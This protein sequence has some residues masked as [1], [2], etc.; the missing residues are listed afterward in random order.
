MWTQSLQLTLLAPWFNMLLL[1]LVVLLLFKTQKLQKHLLV[2]NGASN[3]KQNLLQQTIVQ[4]GESLY[5]G[6][7]VWLDVSNQLQQLNYDYLN[8]R[9]MPEDYAF[10][11]DHLLDEP[12]YDIAQIEMLIQVYFPALLPQ[13]EDIKASL[14]RLA[15]I[16][17]RYDFDP[18]N[19]NDISRY[20]HQW[21]ILVLQ[22]NAFKRMLSMQIQLSI[23]DKHQ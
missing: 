10:Q 2:S 15:D 3:V 13:F 5:Q 18:I 21:Q 8:A 22:S 4:K 7:A 19:S 12:G 6:A 11:L 9:T 23:P 17:N 20:N 1:V 14:Q 16:F